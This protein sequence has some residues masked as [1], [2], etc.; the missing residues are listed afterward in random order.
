M[1]IGALELLKAISEPDK[2][3]A[4]KTPV[5]RVVWSRE[6]LL[7]LLRERKEQLD[8]SHLSIDAIIGWADG[9]SAKTLI[10]IPKKNLSAQTLQ[11]VLDALALGIAGLVVVEDPTQAAA[12]RSRWQQRDGRGPRPK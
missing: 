3:C 10:P 11:L 2:A 9:Y 5:P 4:R 7:K 6:E 1:A 8:I 12:M